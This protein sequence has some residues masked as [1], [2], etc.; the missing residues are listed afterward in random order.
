MF[1]GGRIANSSRRALGLLVAF[2]LCCILLDPAHAAAPAVGTNIT[3]TSSASYLNGVSGAT[4]TVTSNSVVATVNPVPDYTLSGDVTLLRAPD[5]LVLFGYTV[6]NTGNV[7]LTI[8]PTLSAFAGDFN[9]GLVTLAVDDNLDGLIQNSEILAIGDALQLL[10]GEVKSFLVFGHVSELALAGDQASA[11]LNLAAA[12]TTTVLGSQAIILIDT[13]SVTVQKAVSTEN[14]FA[15]DSLTYALTVENASLLPLLPASLYGSDVVTID[16]VV[17][18]VVML[19]DYFPA[20]TTFEQFLSVLDFLPVFH[21]RGD[22]QYAFI[23]TAPADL[24]TVDAVGF[25]RNDPLSPGEFREV[26]FAVTINPAVANASVANDAFVPLA[27]GNGTVILINSNAVSTVIETPSGGPSGVTVYDDAGFQSPASL[28]NFDAPIYV[29]V[30]SQNCNL[31]AQIDTI[32]VLLETQPTG[33]RETVQAIETGPL[34]GVFRVGP[35]TVS[36]DTVVNV[37]DGSLSAS[38][39]DN[40]S[41]SVQCD[42]DIASEVPIETVGFLFNSVTND[43]VSGA[44]VTLVDLSGGV[45]ATAVTDATGRYTL[46]IPATGTYR[47]VVAGLSGYTAPSTITTFDGFNRTIDVT[48]SFGQD[49]FEASAGS[50]VDFDIPVDA[51]TVSTLFLNKIADRNTVSNGRV[52]NY[53]VEIRNS[54][55]SE[56]VNTVVMD[57]LPSGFFFVEGSARFNG[58]ALPDPTGAKTSILTFAVGIIAPV[59]TGNLEYAVRI[60]PNVGSG[61]HINLAA[62]SGLLGGSISL[63]S[64]TAQA[65]VRVDRN[66]SVFSSEGVI[67]GKVF[68]DCNEDGMQNDEHEP[69]IP[70][71]QLYTQEGVSVVTDGNGLFSLPRL[72]AQT[73]V[74]DIYES[75]LPDGSFVAATRVMDAG[76]GG[77]RFVPLRSGEVRSEDFAV[78]SCSANILTDVMA[79]QAEFANAED[80]RK[81]QALRF[82]SVDRAGFSEV[83]EKQVSTVITLPAEQQ[84]GLISGRDG[85]GV[86]SK[87][88]NG[89]EATRDLNAEIKTYTEELDYIDLVDNQVLGSDTVTVRV[90]GAKDGTLQLFV[91]GVEIGEERKGQYVR[92]KSK[93]GVQA[94]EYIALKL[95]PGENI[96]SVAQ[97][98]PFGN[99][100][101]RKEIKVMAPGEPVKIIV[102][103]PEEVRANSQEPFEVV[104]SLVDANNLPV[105]R[106]FEVTLSA[107]DG[108]WLVKDIRDTEPGVQ[109]LMESGHLSVAFKPSGLVGTHLLQ[110]NSAFGLAEVPVRFTAD[111]EKPPVVV[112]YIEGAYS[113]AENRDTLEGLLERDDLSMF[114][115]TQEG[116]NGEVFLKGKIRGDALLTMRFDSER[117]NR[118]RLFR[119]VEP[120]E[121]YP[122][123]GDRSEIGFDAQSRGQLFVKVEKGLSYLLYGDVR[124]G[125]VS[126][127]IQLGAFQRSLEGGKAHIE[128]GRVTVDLYAAHTDSGQ[129]VLEI[130]AQGISGPYALEF[131]NVVENSEVVEILIRDRDQ[132]SQIISSETLSRFAD[133]TLD[134]FAGSIIFS[135]PVQSID[136]NLNPVSIRI[137][138]ETRQGDGE[139]YWV[140]GGEARVDVSDD[141]AIGYRELRADAPGLAESG[142]KDKRIVRSA[143]AEAKL[144]ENSVLQLEFAQTVAD[145]EEVTGPA[146]VIEEKT[147]DAVRLSYAKNTAKSSVNARIGYT[148]EAFDAPGSNQTAG[149][150]EARVQGKT[151]ITEKLSMTSE[152]IYSENT[153]KDETRFGAVARVER[154]IGDQLSGRV[155]ARYVATDGVNEGDSEN[156]DEL[157]SA[158]VGATWAPAF[159]K[160]ANLDTEIEQAIND[161]EHFRLKLGAD[162]TINPKLRA[163]LLSEWSTSDRGAFAIGESTQSNTSLRGGIEYTV[164]DKVKGFSEYRANQ[165]SFDAGIANGLSASWSATDQ[166][167]LRGRVEHVEPLTEVYQGNSAASVGATWEPETVDAVVAGDLEY[168]I[169]ASDSESIYVSNT[170]G[171]K[172]G[173]TTFLARNRYAITEEAEGNRIRDRLRVGAA[174]R[175]STNDKVNALL[176]YEYG[177]ES[178]AQAREESHIWSVAGEYKPDAKTRLHPRYAGQDFTF[179]TGSFSEHT[180]LHMGQL[181]ADRDIVDWF[182]L[183]VNLSLFT[184]A[185]ATNWNAGA[186][187]EGTFLVAD[188]ILLGL[189]YNYATLNEDSLRDLYQE[190]FFVRLRVKFDQDSWNIFSD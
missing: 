143:Y 91:N 50:R 153:S 73:H 95:R 105:H 189:G 142:N 146:P 171:Y 60:G 185:G 80:K 79:R 150:L 186:G 182:N 35:L 116:V 160:G 18:D 68:L 58:T 128:E 32:S 161:S 139:K 115:E 9:V 114:E 74:L 157:L 183:G 110:I 129:Q 78:R 63:T 117:D 179:E 108:E 154:R 147:G 40:L 87:N 29:E 100:R 71:V 124:Y 144:S 75:S 5:D 149:T 47:V 131:D 133:Y 1:L 99:E 48:G 122:V 175:P 64:N 20:D 61:A 107:P 44:T 55:Q 56:V 168:A 126:P 112:G 93:G 37:D 164:V 6:R 83:Y 30:A 43:P 120:D 172:V 187:V 25:L 125:A 69:G 82:D 54:A 180:T 72:R 92:D 111:L 42:P 181:G 59:S 104:L 17:S 136:D 159:L 53:A 155:G 33:D 169:S 152:G 84:D 51:I 130:P 106:P 21:I 127:A 173:D 52:V 96:L 184:E 19:L 81:S 46:G 145:Q 166:V 177:V 2:C 85:A 62:A 7:D 132:P 190:G 103:A 45:V 94:I 134:Y 16:G 8:T 97:V 14:A 174:Y 101:Q 49:F 176:W 89:M 90:K 140:Y 31:T 41:V 188:N 151:R 10:A 15:G 12:E 135:A 123:Y 109:T 88:S 27:Q 38:E 24:S 86:T 137:T 138:F 34:S 36:S 98:D 22:D 102:N 66:S 162:Y 26:S 121:F 119:D 11:T 13:P 141:L 148:D 4:E 3:N 118:D 178:D 170:A 57:H 167:E 76:R 23:T 165:G 156:S 163:Y 67:L 65:S 77:S 28:I 70:G 39:D 158:I 113:F